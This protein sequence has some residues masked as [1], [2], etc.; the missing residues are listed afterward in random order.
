MKK[1]TLKFVSI[2]TIVLLMISNLSMLSMAISIE[3]TEFDINDYTLSDI[4]LMDSEEFS[5]LLNNF[6]RI[7]DP[8]NTYGTEYQATNIINGETAELQWTSG[9][10]DHSE[11]G[12]HELITAKACGYLLSEKGFWSS[13]HNAA[14]LLALTISLASILP[15]VD[16]LQNDILFIGH[17]YD[18]DTETSYL[19]ST[20]NT[21]K[22]NTV[23]FYNDAKSEYIQNGISS[24]FC[25]YVGRMLHYL[26]DANEP[27]HA[28]NITGANLSHPAFESFTYNNI[29]NCFN[30]I[31][32]IPQ[33]SY[34]FATS[35]SVGNIVKYY[36]TLAKQHKSSVNNILNQSNWG[37]VANICV[38][39]AVIS[40]ATLLYK[41]SIDAGIPL[42]IS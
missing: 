28:S 38:R 32:S 20:T 24:D 42:Y 8:F 31:Y 23:S 2:I 30:T 10:A 27:H 9:N 19:G 11:E 40:T 12:T 18:P 21:A 16:Q 6:E 13:N 17:F 5:Y 37:N 35:N 39:N 34:T 1:C 41:L 29:D 36:A 26:Q 33:S 3:N 4:L 15:D 22:T 7:Y 25:E 14:L